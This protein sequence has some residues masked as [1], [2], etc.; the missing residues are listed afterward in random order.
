MTRTSTAL[1]LLLLGSVACFA[2]PAPP[3]TTLPVLPGNAQPL[4]TWP[5]KAPVVE[6]PV[7]AGPVYADH[8]VAYDGHAV[9]GAPYKG[10]GNPESFVHSTTDEWFA[11]PVLFNQPMEPVKTYEWVWFRAEYLV[12]WVKEGPVPGPL[13]SIVPVEDGNILVGDAGTPIFGTEDLDYSLFSAG[14]LGFGFWC[15]CEK[16]LGFEVS[17]IF[18]EERPERF[19]AASSANGIP[20]IGRPFIN[21]LDGSPAA[22]M[23]SLPGE[24]EGNIGISSH[25]RLYGIEINAVTS[26]PWWSDMGMTLLGGVRYLDLWENI[27]FHQST[28][29]L[30][31]GA[32][33]FL[34]TILDSGDILNIDDYFRVHNQFY[35]A[36]MGSSACYSLGDLSLDVRGKVGVGVTHSLVTIRGA[37]QLTGT[38]G[39]QDNQTDAGF[40]AQPTNS[41]RSGRDSFTVAPEVNVQ[42]SYQVAPC[43]RLLAGYT[44]LYWSE[45]ARPGDQIDLVINPTSIPTSPIF[46]PATG[47]GRPAAIFER[48]DFWLQAVSVGLEFRY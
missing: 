36:Q 34:G 11:R 48:T 22:F 39:T 5:L 23:V 30:N 42:L 1:I 37:T 27:D 20:A 38:G 28:T 12:A 14:R 18:L 45:L 29:L 2:Q 7:V 43:C 44:F 33:S 8:G 6:G 47:P 15:D 19:Y 17:G 41:R 24:L 13:V 32:A 4:P 25:S 35:G 3:P 46:N 40:L 9:G 16:A 26:L 31:D 21:A 10:S